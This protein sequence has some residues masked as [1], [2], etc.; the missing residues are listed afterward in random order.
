MKTSRIL[1][2]VLNPIPGLLCGPL[3]AVLV[4]A[5]PGASDAAAPA[6]TAFTY[7][8]WLGAGGQPAN[9][10]YDF[11]FSLWDAATGGN[12]VGGPLS[13]NGV[14]VAG[15][16][17]TVLLDFGAEP[18][19]GQARWL[20]VS[21]R[22]NGEGDFTA[23]APL[24][25]LTASPL[26]LYALNAATCAN[27]SGPIIATNPANEFEGTFAGNA[28]GLTNLNLATAQAGSLPPSAVGFIEASNPPNALLLSTQIVC[29]GDSLTAGTG[30]GAATYPAV[31]SAMTG[32]PV[33]NMGIGSLSSTGILTNFLANPQ[34]WQ[35]PTII[36]SGRNN[37]WDTN[38]V[39]ANIIQMVTNLT[40][41]DWLVMS[42][43]NTTNAGVGTLEY[44][45]IALQLNPLLQAVFT[46][47]YFD[48]RGYLVGDVQV[49][50]DYYSYTNGMPALSLRSD[51]IHLN[52]AGYSAVAAGVL[53]SS[54]MGWNQT[55]LTAGRCLQLLAGSVRMNLGGL[56]SGWNTIYGQD[57]TFGG[58]VNA[59]AA[60]AGTVTATN[61]CYFP[62]ITTAPTAASLGG[63]VGSVT[64]HQVANVNGLLID[65]WSDGV[66]L[67]SKQLAP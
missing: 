36:W 24:Q 14:E 25:P 58:A 27:L 46:N 21:V 61:G 20:E 31:L 62:M 1:P 19:G 60:N 49:P 64:N 65:Y 30:G 26:A 63:R 59:V 37:Y 7:Q 23:L 8:G 32:I 28:V 6:G 4:L 16:L 45:N 40:T 10:L 34:L 42:V 33:A 2:V 35:Y 41:P 11:Q 17:F 18:F 54:F 9:G 13:T 56:G 15:G 53:Q 39:L 22:T 51:F 29:W 48:V 67:Y 43:L 50:S 5:F 44:T 57:G 12:S 66:T 52:A 38:T 47:H 3:A 55:V